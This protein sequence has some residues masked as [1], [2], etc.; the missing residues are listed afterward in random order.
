MDRDRGRVM[1]ERFETLQ[2]KQKNNSY[3][4][5]TF[6]AKCGKSWYDIYYEIAATCSVA[7]RPFNLF[8]CVNVA[9]VKIIRLLT[10]RYF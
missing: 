6:H 1:P 2:K 3:N 4:D 10:L 7:R 8:A 5:D 9:N